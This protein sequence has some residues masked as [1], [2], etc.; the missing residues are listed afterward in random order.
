MISRHVALSGDEQSL[1]RQVCSP[2][3]VEK[4]LG[5]Q[6]LCPQVAPPQAPTQLV[7]SPTALSHLGSAIRLGVGPQETPLTSHTGTLPPSGLELPIS[8]TWILV[9]TVL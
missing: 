6:W 4:Q 7:P 9:T 1:V 5:Q 3:S 2:L 8:R